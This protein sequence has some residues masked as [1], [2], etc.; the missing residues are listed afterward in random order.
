MSKVK[1]LKQNQESKEQ[2]GKNK[3]KQRQSEDKQK[4]SKRTDLISAEREQDGGAGGLIE[5]KNSVSTDV[6]NKNK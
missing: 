6:I 4:Q 3:I 2:I 1:N 5:D